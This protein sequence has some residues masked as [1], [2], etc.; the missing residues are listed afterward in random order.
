MQ[1]SVFLA[2]L[3]VTIVTTALPTIAEAFHSSAGFTWIGS[4]FL[5]GQAASTASWGKLSDIF[6]RKPAL[7]GAVGIFFIGSLICGLAKNIGMLIAGRAIQGL[8]SGGLLVLDN[9]IIADLFSLRLVCVVISI[10]EHL[11]M[12]G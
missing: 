3:D 2:A 9:I 10:V 1:L 8:A 5:L 4:A 6:G 11:L 7:M 12:V